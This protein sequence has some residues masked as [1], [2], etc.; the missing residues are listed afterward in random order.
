MAKLFLNI[1]YELYLYKQNEYNFL[2]LDIIN[3][4]IE[5]YARRLGML[6]LTAATCMDM[7]KVCL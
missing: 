5:Y 1:C 7:G 6:N 3:R 4:D 2:Q